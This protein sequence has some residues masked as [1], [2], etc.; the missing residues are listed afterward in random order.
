[1]IE[2][3]HRW[4]S[5]LL[6]VGLTAALVAHAAHYWPFFSD[7]ALISLRYARRFASGLGL[8][9]SDG[10]RVEGYTDFLWV[11]ILGVFGKFGVDYIACARAIDFVGV[12]AA[13]LLQ[14]FSQLNGRWMPSR[15][16]AS[17]PLLAL[18]APLAVWAIGGLEHGLMA[19]VLALAFLLVGRRILGDE[20]VG[21]ADL[22][23]GVPFAALALLRADGV[24]LVGAALLGALFAAPRHAPR[25][26]RAVV[27]GLPTL[28]AVLAQL[29]FRRLYYGEWQPNTALA[30]LA[31]NSTRLLLGL[32][33]LRAGYGAL[34][35]LLGLALFGTYRLS[36]QKR[37]R[38]AAVPWAV[39][40]AW[41]LY[42]LV[43]GGDI[44]PGYRQLVFP[45]VAL[46]AI[47]ASW[48]EHRNAELRA[49][50]ALLVPACFHLIPQINE[51]ENVRAK[52]ELWEWDGLPV[53][54]ALKAAFGPRKPLLAVDAAGALPYWSE[55]PA[56]D[57]L[58][59]NDRYIA[60]H[61][62]PGFGTGPI[63]HELGD[64]AYVW[65]RKPDLIAFNN[66]AGA[67]DPRFLSGHQLVAMPEFHRVY[68]W[69]RVQGTI[70]N[71]AY[72]EIWMR[73]EGGKLGVERSAERVRIPGYFFTGQASGASARLEKGNKLVAFISNETP[74]ELPALTLGPGR[75]EPRVIGDGAEVT[76]S[77]RCGGVAMNRLGDARSPVLD[78]DEA[79]DVIVSVA[80]KSGTSALEALE[81]VRAD[82]AAPT[83][84]C[85]PRDQPVS[86]SLADV[87]E[88]KRENTFWA[89][90]SNVIFGSAGLS[91]KLGGTLRPKSI[92]IS[93][94]NDDT[95]R[96]DGLLG[97]QP[98]YSKQIALRE[99]GGGLAVHSLPV[100]AGE[101]PLGIDEIRVTPL[102]GDGNF[103]VGHVRVSQ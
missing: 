70:G 50:L 13:I 79:S 89:V 10:E 25:L 28:F 69:V 30:K 76:L 39:V 72:G 52:Q 77:F 58:G 45:I 54:T 7:D 102:A 20:A 93:V 57:M 86:V 59:L 4:A 90:P 18:S 60:H 12:L 40:L 36:L 43:V 100:A 46:G 19:G 53:G 37:L 5:V 42:L 2:S 14:G 33:Y 85:T 8:T 96:V 26:K 16:L 21:R 81:F 63:G 51:S 1:M 32:S 55:L 103:A 49:N 92:E 87:S 22:I 75:F 98:V 82:T 80:P 24:V 73:R 95:Y 29:A 71:R 31:F 15:L 3:E 35:V 17:G 99:N 48:A 74:G 62:P 88:L 6:V 66:A 78:F 27:L 11:F 61:P 101:A 64:G 23:A 56:I 44:F 67:R 97:G 34:I 47:V 38:E 9:W 84:R 91:V 68:Q 83:H 65:S 94:D 41:T